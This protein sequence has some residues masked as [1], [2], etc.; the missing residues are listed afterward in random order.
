MLTCDRTKYMNTHSEILKPSQNI[1]NNTAKL[2]TTLG[3]IHVNKSGTTTVKCCQDPIQESSTYKTAVPQTLV[4]KSRKE[5]EA[6]E[7]E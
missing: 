3:Y 1:N 7:C 2:N 6:T 4:N 5:D